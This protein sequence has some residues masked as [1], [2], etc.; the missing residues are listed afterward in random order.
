MPGRTLDATAKRDELR[1]LLTTATDPAALL[2]AARKAALALEFRATDAM[3]GLDPVADDLLA[4]LRQTID[5]ALAAAAEQGS[6]DAACELAVL[7][8]RARE[9]L[10]ALAL[11]EPVARAHHPRA[12]ALAAQIVWRQGLAHRQADAIAWLEAA[13]ATDPEGHATYM[14]GLYAFNGTGRAVDFTT[15]GRLHEEAAARG[16]ADAMFELYILSDQG[17]GRPADPGAAVAW[18]Q[19]AAEAGNLRAMGNLG[20]FYATGRGL[21]RDPVQALAWY[22]RAAKAGHGKSAATLGVMYA[23]GDCVDTD[24]ERA[25]SWFAAADAIGHDW[26]DLADAVGL[27]PDDWEP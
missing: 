25:R 24:P 15:A 7:R 17:L 10:A 26:R 6:H 2:D 9:H 4:E 18:C 1:A 16:N 21:P 5:T 19:R 11:L 12:A 3:I 14:L 27:D 22:E 20:G 13:R 23:T 8:M